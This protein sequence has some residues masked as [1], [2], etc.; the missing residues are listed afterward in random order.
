MVLYP[1]R[2]MPTTTSIP[3]F[4]ELTELFDLLFEIPLSMPRARNELAT[5]SG[6]KKSQIK[7]TG[8]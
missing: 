6:G 7:A 8:I 3:P 1:M 5:T 2:F 4:V